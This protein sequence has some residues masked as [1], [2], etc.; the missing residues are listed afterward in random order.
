[1][2]L[3][4]S[5]ILVLACPPLV[6][7]QFSN[8][9]GCIHPRWGFNSL[10]QNPCLVAAY[11]ESACGQSTMVSSIDEGFH[12][13]PPNATEANAC[14][15]N[16]VLYSMISACAVCQGRLF[17]TWT[18]WKKNCATIYEGV[19][20]MLNTLSHDTVIP[21]WAFQNIS[22]NDNF[23]ARTVDA[24]L[25]T[26]STSLPSTTSKMTMPPSPTKAKNSSNV[27]AIVGGVVGGVVSL[28]VI[29]LVL[30]WQ[31]MKYR[32]S[33]VENREQTDLAGESQIL[34]PPVLLQMR[35]YGNRSPTMS[36]TPN[37]GYTGAAEVTD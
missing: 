12:Y 28:L 2:I 35:E 32:R 1:M 18:E 36:L 14:R 9:T 16:T 4:L 23:D 5:F 30:L 8:V 27:G 6:A 13:L 21:A 33:R 15:C 37:K 29:L 25:S 31:F 26:S 19:F 24:P 22:Q 7:G 3:I 11:L 10:N 20:P 34:T 17:G